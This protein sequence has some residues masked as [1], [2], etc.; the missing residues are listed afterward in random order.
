VKYKIRI[1]GR[2]YEVE[3][4]ADGLYV[5]GQK[6]DVDLYQTAEKSFHLVAGTQGY[7]LEVAGF[8]SETK[9]LILTV[10]GKKTQVLVQDEFDILLA[11]MGMKAGG[12]KQSKE[13]KAPMPGLV[14]DV[15]ASIGAK[16][17]KGQPLIILEAMKME[18]VLKATG[19]VIVKAIEVKKGMA[20]EKNQVL[21]TFE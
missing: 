8:S 6:F 21:I 19:D 10:N 4:K 20:V 16:I 1:G 13:L 14:V 15:A 5:S 3:K 18:N 17:E 12:A 2:E 11:G 7:N 9:E